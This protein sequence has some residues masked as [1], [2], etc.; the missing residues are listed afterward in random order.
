MRVPLALD[1]KVEA[2]E[3]VEQERGDQWPRPPLASSNVRFRF[4]ASR[5]G[6]VLYALDPGRPDSGRGEVTGLT[7][8]AGDG[9]TAGL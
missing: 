6:F 2:P 8:G 1:G 5:L 9:D 3:P 4:P 7:K